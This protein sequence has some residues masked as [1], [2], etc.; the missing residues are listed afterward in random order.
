[1]KKKDIIKDFNIYNIYNPPP[2]KRE[3]PFTILLLKNILF[4]LNKYI[5]LKNFNLY[6]Y[7]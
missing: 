1:M 6:Y 4:I 7:V 2:V 5:L 3:G